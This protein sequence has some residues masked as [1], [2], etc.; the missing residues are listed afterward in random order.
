MAEICA[1]SLVF[2]FGPPDFQR[3]RCYNLDADVGERS[4]G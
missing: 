1:G 4:Y 2:G 3:T